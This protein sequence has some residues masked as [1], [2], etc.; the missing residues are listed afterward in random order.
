MVEVV[1]VKGREG[2]F[3]WRVSVMLRRINSRGEGS[4]TDVIP[5]AFFQ[6]LSCT[7]AGVKM[8]LSVLHLLPLLGLASAQQAV[9]FSAFSCP[10]V[11][12]G[13]V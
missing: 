5:R 1:R 2:G 9:K 6:S 13:T 10:R 8:Q 12:R 11:L 4:E 3:C 7:C